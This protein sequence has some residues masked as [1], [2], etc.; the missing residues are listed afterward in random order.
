MLGFFLFAIIMVFIGT[1]SDEL[2][3]RNKILALKKVAQSASLSATKYYASE[4][5]NTT[6]AEEIAK[7]IVAST[8]LGAQIVDSLTFD[9]DLISEPK[10]LIVTIPSY[11]EDLFWFRLLGWN[12]KKIE[13]ISSKANIVSSAIAIN[14]C[15]QTYDVGHTYQLIYQETNM[16]NMTHKFSFYN[17]FAINAQNMFNFD[18][19][20]FIQLDTFIGQ[21]I[22]VEVL[23]CDG[24]TKEIIPVHINNGSCA[25]GCCSINFLGQ[26]SF[27]GC[28]IIANMMCTMFDMFEN[29]TDE[30]FNDIIWAEASTENC[31]DANLFKISFTVLDNKVVQLE[32]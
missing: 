17:R 22:N 21:D 7:G 23:D 20:Q 6:K 30:M 10:N 2:Q 27:G 18:V 9:W 26:F 16:F 12:E 13:N 25:K 28:N 14:G 24:S 29:F 8:E 31:N 15:T 11:T 4:D 32:Y 1:I 19:P 3:V 5:E